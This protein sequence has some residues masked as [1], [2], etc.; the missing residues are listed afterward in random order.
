MIR[1]TVI[2]RMD[3]RAD[4]LPKGSSDFHSER[5]RHVMEQTVCGGLIHPP[6]QAVCLAPTLYIERV[7]NSRTFLSVSHS[8]QEPRRC[9]G[10]Y[11]ARKTG[12]LQAV[13]DGQL[14]DIVLP[15]RSAIALYHIRRDAEVTRRLVLLRADL[16]GPTLPKGP[17]ADR[18]GE[19]HP[20]EEYNQHSSADHH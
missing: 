2:V 6:S 16:S 7:G 3:L 15:K 8:P 4:V 10:H 11:P 14:M 13:S 17:N 1:R 20:K 5:F 9:R 12:L 19:D 18:Y